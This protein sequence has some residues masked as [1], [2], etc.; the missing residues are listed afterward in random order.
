MS[1]TCEVK[2]IQQNSAGAVVDR[3]NQAFNQAKT[4]YLSCL[5][6]QEQGA[7]LV[8]D[9]KPAMD[10]LAKEAEAITYMERFMLGQLKRE[11]TNE[12]TMTVLSESAQD[13]ADKVRKEIE[14]LKTE[15]RTEKRR[16]LDSGP[17]APVAIG[18][19]YFLNQPDNQVLIAFLSCFGA[20]LLFTSIIFVMNYIPIPTVRA[21]L[22]NVTMGERLS[23]VAGVWAISFAIMYLSFFIFT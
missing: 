7:A 18:G 20:F 4:D 23:T 14:E 11:V 5:G 1:K 19:F 12:Q 21:Y 22:E 2:R 15:I 10:A 13:E 6:P 8:A 16:F 17:S 9:A 3:A